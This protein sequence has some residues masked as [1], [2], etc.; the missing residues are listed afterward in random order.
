L[1]RFV[2]N[3]VQQQTQLILRSSLASPAYSREKSGFKA[4]GAVP[5]THPREDKHSQHLQ[6]H[7]PRNRRRNLTTDYSRTRLSLRP[8]PEE[9]GNTS[10]YLTFRGIA[11]CINPQGRYE[12]V[13][14]SLCAVAK[15]I[16]L[17]PA[18][19]C[20]FSLKLRFRRHN[21]QPIRNESRRR[22]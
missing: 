17:H 16:L 7:L 3:T 13:A 1:Q 4:P 8:L 20:G 10:E 19:H 15:E 5:G 22:D 12:P 18:G 2:E 6:L 14:P 9:S 11:L 21:E